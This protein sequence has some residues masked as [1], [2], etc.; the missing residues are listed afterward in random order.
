[1]NLLREKLR[2][3][4]HHRA[5]KGGSS[6]SNASSNTTMTTNI[7]RR[8]VLQDAA[9]V[10]DNSTSSVNFI[11]NSTDGEVLKE[12][13]AGQSDA[14]KFMTQQGATLLKDAGGAIVDLNKDSLTANTKAWDSTLQYGSAMVDS[15]ID[16][17]SQGYGIAEKAIDK[18]Q[19]TENANADIGKYAMI[20]VAVVAGVV[21]LKDA[22]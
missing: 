17:M 9:Y 3:C 12:L 5:M 8:A 13:A 7:D 18:F 6:S 21:F 2:A 19:P 20:A 22:K 10:G 4:G 16:S 11:N 14:V 1:M 15:I